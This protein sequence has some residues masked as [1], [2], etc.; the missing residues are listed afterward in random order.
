MFNPEVSVE[1]N[2]SEMNSAISKTKSASVTYA[3]KDT[4]FEG[5]DIKAGDYMGILEKSIVVSTKDK[6]EAVQ[7]LLDKAITDEDGLVTLIVGEDVD[8]TESDAV[9]AYIENHHSHCELEL[10]SGQQPVYS[11]I[12]GIE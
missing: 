8:S 9:V 6:L 3:V 10:I 2:I 5:I 11:Y 7:T 1:E 12:I 4:S